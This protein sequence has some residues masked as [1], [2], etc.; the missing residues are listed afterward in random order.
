[1]HASLSAATAASSPTRPEP[2]RLG[3][4]AD[5][6]AAA[7]RACTTAC[8]SAFRRNGGE[9]QQSCYPRGERARCG[10]RQAARFDAFLIVVGPVFAR[11]HI[12]VHT[13]LI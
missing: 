4:A 12:H 11:I 3:A 13:K 7:D 5:T 2:C 1:M 8:S 6:A 10:R 9:W